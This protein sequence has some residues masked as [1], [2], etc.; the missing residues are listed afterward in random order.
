MP[1][2]SYKQQAFSS[3]SSGKYLHLAD[4]RSFVLLQETKATPG[5]DSLTPSI[6]PTPS[7][8]MPAPGLQL[9]TQGRPPPR[10]PTSCRTI[11][12]V[13]INSPE[14]CRSRLLSAEGK[15]AFFELQEGCRLKQYFQIV[16]NATVYGRRA[17]LNSD[18]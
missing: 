4:S 6:A 14:S 1:L 15:P 3:R 9:N 2:H 5:P 7:P 18:P 10:V 17:K 8:G 13:L 16:Y 12:R 11:R